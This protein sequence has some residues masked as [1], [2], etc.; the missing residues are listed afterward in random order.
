[1]GRNEKKANGLLRALSLFTRADLEQ[2]EYQLNNRVCE[3]IAHLNRLPAP[4]G[5]RIR[6]GIGAPQTNMK[7]YPD[8]NPREPPKIQY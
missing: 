4:G 2:L 3:P 5:W 1:M 6:S 8:P 7:R